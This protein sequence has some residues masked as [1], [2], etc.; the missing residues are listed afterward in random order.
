VLVTAHDKT[1]LDEVAG[2]NDLR[3]LRIEG[4]MTASGPDFRQTWLWRQAF[5]NPRS[6]T[7]TEEQEFFRTQYLSIRDRAAQLVSR[8]AVDF[9]GMTVHD[10]SHLDALWDTASA[11]A[12]GAVNVNPA[13]AFVL[14]GSILLHDAA[15]S[16]AAY[17]GG[18]AQVRTTVAWKDAVARIVLAAEE[19][20]GD[21]I[22]PANPPEVVVRQII[23]DVLRRLHAEHAEV[24]AE[25]AW[26]S[27][28][29]QQYL[30]ED[31]ELRAFYG[32]TI[33]RIAHSHWWSVH[34]V[35][36]E[37]SEDLGALANRTRGLVDRVK[38]ACL[39]RVADALH[40]DSRR[41][42]RFLRAIT[43]PGGVSALHWAFQERLA[44]PHIELDAVVFTSGQPFNRHE[45][46][47]WWLAYD[48]LNAVDREL[49]DVDL[50]LQ[51]RGREVLK[52]RRVKGAGSPEILSRTIQTR[53]W[54][55]V[56][57][58]LQ[59]SDVPRIV[60]SL[61]GSK[62]YGDDPTVALRELIQ[63]AAD[64]VQARRRFQKRSAD[65]G[66]IT[67]SLPQR[68]EE[69]WLIV[70]DNGIGM[71]EQVLTGPLLDFGTSFWRSAMAME[72][73]PGLMASGMHAIGRFGIGFFSVFMLGSVVRVYSRR[74]D[75]G[76]E[77]ARLLEFQ[78][79]TS[80]RPILSPADQDSA[81]IDGGTRVEVLL[82]RNP[83]DAGGVLHSTYR[84]EAIPLA[85]LV[86]AVAPNL[87]VALFVR[88]DDKDRP[89]V[90]P[91]DWLQM[92]AP[93]LLRRLNPLLD[94]SSDEGRGTDG[95]L[96][97][98]LAGED[99]RIFGR[100]FINAERWSWSSDGWVTVSGLRASKMRNL[101]GVLLGEAITAARDSAQ[102]SVGAGLLARWASEQA[103]LIAG[104]V[105]DE[106]RQA[107]SAEV[108][109]E[110]G[111]DIGAL[112]IVKWGPDWLDAAELEERLRS[113]KEFVVTFAGEFDYDEDRDGVHPR[114]F[115]DAFKLAPD[116]SI[117]LKHDGAILA[118]NYSWPSAV[119]G[120][121][122]PQDSNVGTHVRSIVGRVWNN[123]FEEC[124]E[125]RAVGKVGDYEDI[126][127][128]VTV[129]RRADKDEE[130]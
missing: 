47:A 41:A 39:L 6:D 58:R 104:T 45:A 81:P 38:L 84:K 18:L 118:A 22:D 20:G 80:S 125:E 115:R 70:E 62:L 117:V 68:G 53:G 63:N 124:R 114:D 105:A 123:D 59:A 33:G 43:N 29:N 103:G 121:S 13:E 7:T 112:K 129:F 54:R 97:K 37:L 77:T 90:R 35:E 44:R 34:K 64:A 94:R 50:L 71:S 109:L 1:T 91:G 126:T 101:Q 122:T 92:K 130:F 96:M 106:E 95:S 108:V 57:A 28:R 100:A 42:P 67:V 69:F 46:E 113:C 52:A 65:W 78:G 61:G 23:P 17:P 110:C 2:I 79:G 19:G 3:R 119:T 85:R 93:D 30:I 120:Q 25:Q 75:K 102:P 128:R 12:E 99:G 32:A 56:D 36:Q 24:L 72:E 76:Q 73:F 40:L 21:C 4:K 14:G 26:T 51:S 98:P 27:D 86:G 48:T 111:G 83:S 66:Q 15:M 87:D 107:R 10:V 82:K 11:V 60:E 127:R 5:V 16:L 116:V 55:P 89:I 8:I 49:R 31:S 74:C 9:P 88:K